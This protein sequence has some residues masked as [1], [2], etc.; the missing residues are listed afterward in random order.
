MQSSIPA[1]PL[2]IFQR[3][4]V[5]QPSPPGGAAPNAPFP[6]ALH[7][8]LLANCWIPDQLPRLT[9][10]SRGAKSYIT[11][12]EASSLLRDTPIDLPPR[13]FKALARV[14]ARTGNCPNRH[15][16]DSID[17]ALLSYA[18]AITMDRSADQASWWFA[19]Y[20]QEEWAI[21]KLLPQIEIPALSRVEPQLGSLIRRTIAEARLD[22]VAEIRRYETQLNSKNL[23][24]GFG[25]WV[26]GFGK[27]KE[28]ELRAS[29]SHMIHL[30]NH[31]GGG[32][33]SISELLQAAA[34]MKVSQSTPAPIQSRNL[35]DCKTSV[36]P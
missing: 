18:T 34:G 7:G 36:Q 9:E 13:I 3:F 25:D 28:D 27:L 14:H 8:W 24:A 12:H 31:Y 23:P 22:P 2:K 20:C 26:L 15:P 17:G 32:L 29:V 6:R 19:L 5:G 11:P 21:E 10:S 35:N 30:I 33:Q 16:T 1:S 4:L